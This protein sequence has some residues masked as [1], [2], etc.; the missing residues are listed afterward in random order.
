M[1]T[2]QTYP[3]EVG[4]NPAITPPA[5]APP[6]AGWVQQG[7]TPPGNP[8]PS[9]PIALWTA[10][11][12]LAI[13]LVGSL[14]F[15]IVTL[16]KVTT[17]QTSSPA[18]TTVTAPVAT[19]V[20]FDD[21]ADRSLCAAI[22]D[23]MR[24]RDTADQNYQALPPSGSPERRAALPAYKQGMEDWARRLQ[25]VIQDHSNPDR[26]LTR[27]LQRYV[28][29]KLLYSQNIYK[30]KADRFDGATWDTGVVSYGGALGRCNQLGLVW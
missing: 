2:T 6:V 5:G 9:G 13:G 1:S 15:S 4:P 26:Y 12:V 29:D 28:D 18:T 21:V 24:E 10:I 3:Y 16:N 7:A 22:P 19:P 25:K 30:D 20:L 8:R 14:I 17:A 11:A 23:L 27:T